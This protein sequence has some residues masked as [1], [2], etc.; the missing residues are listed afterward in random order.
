MTRGL[1]LGLGLG[2]WRADGEK[3]KRREKRIEAFKREKKPL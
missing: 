3:K 2:W 1:R